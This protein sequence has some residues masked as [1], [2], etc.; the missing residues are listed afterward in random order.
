MAH[1]WDGTV[2]V[3]QWNSGA[4]STATPTFTTIVH[5]GE[6]TMSK[7]LF[8]ESLALG[9]KAHRKPCVRLDEY[10]NQLVGPLA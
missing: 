10:R 3:L 6:W 2:A 1:V 4:F 7:A 9:S 8:V 5:F